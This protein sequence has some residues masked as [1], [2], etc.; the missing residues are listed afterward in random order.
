M[1][2][3][4]RSADA[5]LS[6]AD[7]LIKRIVRDASSVLMSDAAKSVFVSIVNLTD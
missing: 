5:V 7:Q 1:K 6:V 2:G 4:M 3:L